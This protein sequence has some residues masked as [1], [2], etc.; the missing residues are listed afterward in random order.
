MFGGGLSNHLPIVADFDESLIN[1]LVRSN[2][3]RFGAN[4]KAR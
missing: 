1:G 2:D 4:S 3:A